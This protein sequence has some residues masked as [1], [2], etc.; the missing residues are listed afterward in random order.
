MRS[1]RYIRIIGTG[2]ALQAGKVAFASPLGGAGGQAAG[3]ITSLISAAGTVVG[4]AVVAIGGGLAAWKA[5]TGQ[6]WTHHLA[7]AAVGAAIA[8]VSF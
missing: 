4:I 1:L 3:D 7:T 6:E 5:A 2:L 8:A